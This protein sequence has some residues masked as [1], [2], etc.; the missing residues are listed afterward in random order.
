VGCLDFVG[1]VVG[2]KQFEGSRVGVNAADDKIERVE[3]SDYNIGIEALG[4]P[5][6]GIQCLSQPSVVELFTGQPGVLEQMGKVK[7]GERFLDVR[8]GVGSEE[9]GTQQRFDT[10]A[11]GDRLKGMRRNL[12]ID[13]LLHLHSPKIMHHNG[14]RTEF[15]DINFR[16][17][18]K[19]K[20]HG[21]T[22]ERYFRKSSPFKGRVPANLHHWRVNN[23]FRLKA[24]HRE[25]GMK[26][27]V[28]QFTQ[29]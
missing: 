14:K 21:F 23:K 7:L 24:V 19:G 3:T 1:E 25:C 22:S 28:S 10:L 9:N 16:G 27:S 15:P 11:M 4:L 2:T 8:K 20:G 18:L 29:R 6:E 26:G 5:I 13:K 17:Y 12:G